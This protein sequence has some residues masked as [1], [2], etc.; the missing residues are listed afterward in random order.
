M[1]ERTRYLMNIITRKRIIIVLL[2]VLILLFVGTFTIKEQ[3]YDTRDMIV[4]MGKA[5]NIEHSKY[6]IV[7][8]FNDILPV[9]QHIN[10]DYIDYTTKEYCFF[11]L[12]I[13]RNIDY[14]KEVSHLVDI[15]SRKIV[16]SINHSKYT[17]HWYDEEYRKDYYY[18][19]QNDEH[20]C[21]ETYINKSIFDYTKNK[22]GY[23]LYNVDNREIK[24]SEELDY[25]QE[26]YIFLQ[27]YVYP[28]KEWRNSDRVV[29]Y[30]LTD[31][32][33]Y[34]ANGLKY[35]KVFTGLY[36]ARQYEPMGVPLVLKVADLPTNNQK[37]YEEFPYLL[38]AKKDISLQNCYVIL[39]FPYS[40]NADEAVKMIIE[41][42]HAVSYEG[43][44][45]DEEYT[46]DGEVHY[47]NSFDEFLQYVDV[48][49]TEG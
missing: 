32:N 33:Y 44:F 6:F 24:K 43:V 49:E 8:N 27:Q 5:Q 41:E 16:S 45:L 40:V 12:I 42:G 23:V 48:I 36:D 11:D 26:D 28:E 22:S 25:Y 19:Y 31:E 34:E 39:I 1:N 30:L 14:R 3:Y 20:L 21:L 7:E 9:I 10:F 37:L 38:K 35:D 2:V 46:K 15:D 18:I 13:Q 4:A 47:I 17:K 29:Q